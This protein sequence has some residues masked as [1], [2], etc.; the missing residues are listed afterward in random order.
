MLNINLDIVIIIGIG[1]EVNKE[2][3]FEYYK[4]AAEKGH[5]IA[6][7]SLGVCYKNGEGV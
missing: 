2:K 4:I 3:T 1:T 5:S 7:Y 6:Q